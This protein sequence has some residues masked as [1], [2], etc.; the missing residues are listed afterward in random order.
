MKASMEP[1]RWRILSHSV[2]RMQAYIEADTKEEALA[3][4]KAMA[5]VGWDFEDVIGDYEIVSVE[6][7]DD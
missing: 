3:T 6:P 2:N 7:A 4:A 1:K 5:P